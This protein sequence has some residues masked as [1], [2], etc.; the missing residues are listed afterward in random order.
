[1]VFML[2]SLCFWDGFGLLFLD[3]NVVVVLDGLV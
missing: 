2:V 3:G 1:M